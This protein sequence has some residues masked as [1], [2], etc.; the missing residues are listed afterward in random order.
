MERRITAI[1]IGDVVG[2][3]AQMAASEERAIE[4]IAHGLALMS[5]C[6]AANGGRVFNT[7]GDALLA[8]F[9]SPV[10]ALRAAIEA[11]SALAASPDLT[12]QDMR[13]GLHLADVAVLGTDLRGDGVNV[14]ARIQQAAQPGAIDVSQALHDHV[15]R[16]SPC[17]FEDM[18]EQRFKGIE[19]PLRI[20]RVGAS[21]DRH[22]YQTAPTQVPEQTPARPNSVAVVPFHVAG[23][24]D[25]DQH[26]LAEGLT[27]DII[28][29]LS[30]FRQLFVTS[31]TASRALGSQDPVETGRLL[32][33]R[34]ALSGSVRKL[35]NRLRL[36]IT[37]S[38]TAHG[39][40]VWTEKIQRPFDE[41]LD[42]MDEIAARVAATVSGRID[43]A[44]ITAARMKR[45]QN[46]NAYEYYLRGLE[47][48]RLAGVSN[49][50]AAEAM[51]WFRKA[52]EADPNFARPLAMYVCAWS[53]FPEFDVQD[54]RDPLMRAIK[55]DDCDPEVHRVLGV[56]EIQANDDWEASRLHH[57]MAIKLAPSDAY[58]LG[59]C[60]AF[61]TF[62][63]EP[64]RALALLDRAEA[65]DPFLP[66]WIVEERIAA[67]YALRRFD[68]MRA[69]A[70][71]LSFQTRRTRLYRAAA[72]MIE[73]EAARAEALIAAALAD[74]P[75]LSIAYLRAQEL[76]R[77]AAVIDE[78]ASM[79]S[80]AGLPE[81][82][83]SVVLQRVS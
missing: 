80:A 72:R 49:D 15:A 14:A 42:V 79:L 26:F 71:N 10:N 60:A 36:N 63:G 20:Y 21:V 18:G 33:V 7:A 3:T 67:L 1:L 13:F 44:E 2:S 43:H 41:V 47:E 53:Y 64:E 11:R 54:A 65:L 38:E 4:R 45:P 23:T 57:E 70:R 12:P 77:D 83:D 48:H 35:G 6:V 66:V 81:T 19:T 24:G 61:Y 8:E 9:A 25:E 40:V 58:I 28:H 59:R 82:A 51:K 5:D 68:E 73:G 32:G 52:Q 29:E 74:D 27:E 39:E 62:A 30:R 17:H 55:L 50:H 31:R 46:M 78:L 22:V 37:L 69:A 34:Y 76:F 75:K 16:V 56:F